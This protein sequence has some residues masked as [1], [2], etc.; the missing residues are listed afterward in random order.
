MR[1][2][3]PLDAF[4]STDVVFTAKMQ[5]R[6]ATTL[7][8]LHAFTTLLQVVIAEVQTEIQQKLGK[9]V[10]IMPLVDVSRGS[11]VITLNIK[12]GPMSVELEVPLNEAFIAAV[13]ALS[14]NA[15]SKNVPLPP[16]T[17]S[18]PCIAAIESAH[19]DAVTAWTYFGRGVDATYQAKCGEMEIRSNI[20]VAPTKR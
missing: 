18:A 16:P 4:V 2:T 11:I 12:V 19:R 17:L 10:E 15:V 9:S 3:L 5:I 14:P 7:D 20:K 1:T 6:G 8:D 13:L